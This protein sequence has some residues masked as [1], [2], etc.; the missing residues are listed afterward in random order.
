MKTAAKKV[1]LNEVAE[2]LLERID[3]T[4]MVLMSEVK[5]FVELNELSRLSKR[6]IVEFCAVGYRRPC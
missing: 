2:R 3:A 5:S 6:G 1:F 4:G